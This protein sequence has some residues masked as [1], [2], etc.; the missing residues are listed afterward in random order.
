MRPEARKKMGYYPA[1]PE[2]IANIL[3]RLVPP[4]DPSQVA[5]FDPC[6]GEGHAIKGLARGLGIPDQRVWLVELARDGGDA[7]REAFPGATVLSP[8]SFLSTDIRHGAYSL[9]YANPPFDDSLT[10]GVRVEEQFLSYSLRLLCTG[11]VLLFVCPESIAQR[12]GFMNILSTY[13]QNIDVVQFP[14]LVRKHDEVFV[15]A[16]RIEGFR[17]EKGSY[18]DLLARGNGKYSIPKAP[19]PGARFKKTGLTDDE[20]EEYL[21]RSVLLDEFRAPPEFTMPS[22]PLA[23]GKGHLALLLAAGNL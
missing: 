23:L 3:H 14:R 22:P 1:P 12:S 4:S 20:L 6:A 9:V 18:R 5:L 11:G 19:G 2:A 7:C 17:M 13:C 16:Q 8:C 21:A 10:K 15:L